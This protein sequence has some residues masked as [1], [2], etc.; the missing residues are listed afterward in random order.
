MLLAELIKE[1]KDHIQSSRKGIY[2]V[3][4]SILPQGVSL[5]TGVVTS[6][7]LARGL[8]PSELG[9]YTLI[10]SVS[11]MISSLSDLGIGQTA[12]RFASRCMA[13]N[14]ETGHRAV[15]RW[16]FRI[17]VLL[18]LAVSC[19]TFFLSPLLARQFWHDESLSPLIRLSLVIGFLGAVASVSTI[20]F[21]S[22]KRFRANSAVMIFQALTLMA[23]IVGLEFFQVWTLEWVIIVSIMAY[24]VNAAAFLILV[25]K[26]SIFKISD[27]EYLRHGAVNYIKSPKFRN[28]STE[29]P[30]ESTATVFA[31]FMMLSA[32]VVM[33]VVK[34]DIWLM[35]Y[36]LEPHQIGIYSA[37]SRFAL[38]LM[39]VVTAMNT[40]LWPRT[41]NLQQQP[42]VRK[43]VRGIFMMS[44]L[45]ALAGVAYAAVAPFFIPYVFGEAYAS[46]VILGQLL[47]FRFCLSLFLSPVG[48]IG[49]NYGFVRIIWLV[50]I[51][52]LIV[53]ILVNIWL[54]PL[55]GPIGSAIA[56][57]SQ[58]LIGGVIAF[59]IIMRKMKR[60]LNLH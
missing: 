58:E 22:L 17:R 48:I 50:N 24:A 30:D 44:G 59:F 14:D 55:Y 37:A 20:Y 40:V 56:L 7:L 49:L 12:I 11:A 45:V 19:I 26:D 51:I 5:V 36:F 13:N 27:F 18:V 23:G 52:Q 42:D 39:M 8:G 43:F 35:G 29:T 21:Q 32:G 10:I 47:C 53:I 25:P 38:P 34:A 46:G 1:Y 15:L 28:Y 16:A 3:F 60:S 41:S 2:D 33:L 57:I 54:L 6:V 4:I 9:K 31:F